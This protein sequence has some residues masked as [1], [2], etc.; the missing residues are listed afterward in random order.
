MIFRHKFSFPS[1]KTTL[2]TSD[3]RAKSVV[4][5]CDGA[6]VSKYRR[7]AC[8]TEL[9]LAVRARSRTEERIGFKAGV[10]DRHRAIGSDKL[11]A[12]RMCEMRECPR[13]LSLARSLALHLAH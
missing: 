1:T 4:E 6:E 12:E 7:D 2:T 13:R 5:E 8:V 3:C 9:C 10:V 11:M